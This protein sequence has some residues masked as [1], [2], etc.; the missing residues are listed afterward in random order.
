MPQRKKKWRG[1]WKKHKTLTYSNIQKQDEEILKGTKKPS[2]YGNHKTKRK[3]IPF[4]S[5][6]WE[7]RQSSEKNEACQSVDQIQL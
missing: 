7:Y 4:F 1:K 6:I 3:N 2:W 5:Q